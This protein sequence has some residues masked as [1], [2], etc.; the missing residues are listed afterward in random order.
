MT[1]RFLYL[2]I[3]SSSKYVLVP[4][5]S[6]SSQAPLGLLKENIFGSNSCKEKLHFGHECLFDNRKFTSP[7]C[8]STDPSEN[9]NAVS[10]DSVSLCLQSSSSSI[11]S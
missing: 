7:D 5:P 10:I 2:T 8:M 9:L 3:L 11:I 1:L 4:R 6:H